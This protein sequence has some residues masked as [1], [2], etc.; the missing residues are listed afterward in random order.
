MSIEGFLKQELTE[1]F[2]T[3]RPRHIRVLGG[4]AEAAFM[5]NM[6]FRCKLKP[7]DWF[8]HTATQ[9]EEETTLSTDQ[10]LRVRK[11]LVALGVLEEERRGIP[12]KLYFRV[13]WEAYAKLLYPDKE[14][15]MP[16]QDSE[17]LRNCTPRNSDT[18]KNKE[19]N[20]NPSGAK[21]EILTDPKPYNLWKWWQDA[22]GFTDVTPTGR[23]LANAKELIKRGFGDQQKFLAYLDWI[24]ADAF[25]VQKGI[26]LA[27]MLTLAN[28]YRTARVAPKIKDV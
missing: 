19:K 26:D 9:I 16:N 8:Y 17:N 5:S 20:H 3:L 13:N 6:C 14:L 25:W 24:R 12:S 22:F 21:Q 7:D 2:I 4:M 10:Q 11:K 23:E 18:N 1:P 27:L 15:D 28:R